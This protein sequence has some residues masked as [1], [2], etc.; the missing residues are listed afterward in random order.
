MC[1]VF[2]VFGHPEA[3]NMAYLGLHSL[4]HRGQ[5]SAGIVSSDGRSLRVHKRMGRVADIFD[6]PALARLPG[7]AAI[8]HV[9]Y[10]T[11]GMSVLKNAKPFAVE[12]R[13]TSL[14]IAHN[15]NLTNAAAL[16]DELERGGALFHTAM[17]TEVIVHLIARASG[18]SLVERVRE[19]MGL[20]EG[21]YSLLLLTPEQ[22]V[23]V[24]DP[25]GFRPLVVG[26]LGDGYVVSSETCGLRLVEATYEREVEPGEILV[27][28]AGGMEGHAGVRADRVSPHHCIFE[29]IYFARPDSVVFGSAVYGVRVAIGERLAAEAPAPGADLV[30]PV[31]DSGIAA[32]IGY[33]R[34]AGLPYEMGLIRS[35]YTGRTFIEPSQSIRHFGVKLKLSPVE[36]VIRG[37]SVVVVDDSLVRGTTSRKIVELL[38]DSGAREV[39]VRIA[40][41]PTCGSCFYGID[42]PDQGELIAARHTVDGTRRFLGADSLAYLGLEG[43]HRAVPSGGRDY[44]DACFTRRYPVPVDQRDQRPLR[45]SEHL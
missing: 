29:H 22:L 12:Y 26:R 28:D 34:A 10:S 40:C 5:E 43:L 35:H 31:P 33:A 36:Q 2:G 25:H 19:V 39:H 24:R 18:E 21:A 7:E 41:P 20:V 37:R 42:T 27:M 17:D 23:A 14:A 9:R 6:A 44:C 16:R 30:I 45:L 1:G 38:R 15:G 4:Q 11:S 8:G 13:G 32:A 3:A